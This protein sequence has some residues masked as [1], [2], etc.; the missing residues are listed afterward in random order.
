[1]GTV[2]YLIDNTIL[3]IREDLTSPKRMDKMKTLIG[4]EKQTKWAESLRAEY[5]RLVKEFGGINVDCEYSKFWI[6]NAQ[7]TSITYSNL[8]LKL[9]AYNFIHSANFIDATQSSVKAYIASEKITR[10]AAMMIYRGE[11]K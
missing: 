3:L 8:P 10:D 7:V 9:E 4:S 2:I 1:M 6:E 11:V 5:L